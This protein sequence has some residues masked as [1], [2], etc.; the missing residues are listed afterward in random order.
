MATHKLTDGYIEGLDKGKDRVIWDA[1]LPRFGVRVTPAGKRLY[2][3]QYRAKPAPGVPSA[4]RKVGIGEHDGKLWNVT[5]A[6]AQA[7]KVLGAV[8]A[9]GDPVAERIAQA[10]AEALAKAEA[11]GLA[12]D[13]AALAQARERDRFE[14][15]AERYIAASLAGKKSGREFARHL[16][17]GPI[18]A[19]QGRHIAA[20]RRVDVRDLLDEIAKRSPASARLTYATLRGLFGWCIEREIIEISP[21]DHI[22][23]P[24]RPPARDRVLSEDELRAVWQGANGLGYPFGPILKL[25]MLTGQREAEVAGMSWDE[26]DLEAATWNLPKERTKNGRAHAVDLS[27]EAVEIIEALP[28]VGDLLFPARN[29]PARKHVRLEGENGPRPVAGFSAAKRIL[30]GDVRRKTKADLPTAGLAPWRIHDLRRTAATGMA[31]MGFPP[32]VVERV[33]NHA[34]GVNGGLVGVYQRHE[35]RTERKTALEAWGNRVAAIVS[36]EALPSNV[37]KLRA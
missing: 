32:H 3:V 9:G 29:A 31:G 36:G 35:Y 24:P 27:L 4:T 12:A 2:I 30:D 23:A 37:R 19:W 6:R 14:A 26:I 34:S 16:R 7:R 18:D 5:K 1:E 17:R 15:V 21:C 13:A 10:A 25:L 20:I 22:K 8:D 33:L 28:R 11:A